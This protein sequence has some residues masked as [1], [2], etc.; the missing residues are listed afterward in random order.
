M[1]GVALVHYDGDM[2]RALTEAVKLIGGFGALSSPVIIKPNLCADV[3]VTGVAT[4]RVQTVE[5]LLHL[6]LEQDG[7]LAVRIVE[8]DS[9]SKDAEAAFQKLGF[10]QLAARFTA[11]G[12][13][14][15]LV[16]LSQ[17]PTAVVAWDGLYF[18][19]PRLPTVLAE[20]GYVISLAVPKTH[21][22]TYVTGV[23]KNLFGLLPRKDQAAYHP[24]IH[25][26]IVDLNRLIRPDLGVIDAVWGLE[27]V[28]RGRPRRVD[29]VLAGRQP[30]A[31]DATMARVMGFD[32]ERIRHLAMAVPYD[33][34]LLR[35]PILGMPLAAATVP[36]DPPRPVH[37]AALL[38]EARR[39]A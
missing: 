29:V 22:L 5:A 9:E 35:P 32:P 17:E 14:V 16:N 15:A 27:G 11:A 1:S 2:K 33:L 4:T 38:A 26:V 39:S 21:S 13:D 25:E 6:L 19:Q 31:V 30:L 37:A 20:A 23:M 3:D 34:G 7:A 8:S 18:K 24:Q 28:L 10:T 36:F 12:F